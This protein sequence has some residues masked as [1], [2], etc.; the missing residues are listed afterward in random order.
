M[1]LPSFT[2]DSEV[3]FTFEKKSHPF[4]MALGSTYSKGQWS[5]FFTQLPN[6]P[7]RRLRIPSY[8]PM[9]IYRWMPSTAAVFTCAVC[10]FSVCG[11]V[12]NL[13]I[14]KYLWSPMCSRTSIDRRPWNLELFRS[15]SLG[16]FA[17]TP[18]SSIR[19]VDT[20][21]TLIYIST[22]QSCLLCSWPTS[23]LLS[24]LW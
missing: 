6:G 5:W 10:T 20:E 9:D 13:Y 22:E 19:I 23:L 3:F 18:Y 15:H 14:L 7:R 2:G 16:L 17:D 1:F 12:I 4:S 8:M 24:S 11:N 21:K